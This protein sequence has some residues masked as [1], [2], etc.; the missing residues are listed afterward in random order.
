MSLLLP[1]FIPFFDQQRLFFGFKHRAITVT[2]QAVRSLRNIY[3]LQPT[4]KTKY[5]TIILRRLGK[6]HVVQYSFETIIWSNITDS[7]G[8]H[9]TPKYKLVP[10]IH[11]DGEVDVNNLIKLKK[12]FVLQ[13]MFLRQMLMAFGEIYDSAEQ[14]LN[15]S[16]L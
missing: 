2:T 16:D 9:F 11:R 14:G 5:C 3:P 13:V 15:N 1:S 7:L 4:S 10:N 6:K 8:G 12:S